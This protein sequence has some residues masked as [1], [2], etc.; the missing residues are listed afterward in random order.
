MPRLSRSEALRGPARIFEAA[1]RT[2]YRPGA[3]YHGPVRLASVRDANLDDKADLQS[4]EQ[5][6]A[7]WKQWAPNVILWR[8]SG[9]HM[10]ML[11]RP[12]VGALAEWLRTEVFPV[13]QR[14]RWRIWGWGK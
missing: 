9:N 11:K 6:L 13:N 3:V 8:G 10:T 12:N 7:G 14:N 4:S 2:G 5:V 1:L